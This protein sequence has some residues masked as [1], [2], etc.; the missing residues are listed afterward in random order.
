MVHRGWHIRLFYEGLIWNWTNIHENI[1]ECRGVSLS[2]LL[3]LCPSWLLLTLRFHLP[4]SGCVQGCGGARR[5]E[6]NGTSELGRSGKPVWITLL[7]NGR[8]LGWY[9]NAMINESARQSVL[10]VQSAK[11]LNM[12]QML[13]GVFDC[14]FFYKPA[15]M[16]AIL[17]S[18]H[19]FNCLGELGSSSLLSSSSL[20]SHSVI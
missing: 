5:C 4:Q 7:Y 16:T 9:K 11:T 2:F 6:T 12:S 19:S 8:L 17:K 1:L 20:D 10:P 13:Q 18:S 15:L 3:S 14:F